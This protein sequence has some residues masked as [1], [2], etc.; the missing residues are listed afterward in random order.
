MLIIPLMPIKAGQRFDLGALEAEATPLIAGVLQGF[1]LHAQGQP[2]CLLVDVLHTTSKQSQDCLRKLL[3]NHALSVPAQAKSS[4]CVLFRS[5]GHWQGQRICVRLSNY[6][7]AIAELSTSTSMS[8]SPT[9]LHMLC[10][11]ALLQ[12]VKFGLCCQV[13]AAPRHLHQKGHKWH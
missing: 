2:T 3:Y 6:K 7:A 1:S 11:D 4:A 8:L 13:G 10:T 12:A 5:S 9:Y